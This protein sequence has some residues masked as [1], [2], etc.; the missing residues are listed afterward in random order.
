[1]LKADNLSDLWNLQNI[2]NYSSAKTIAHTCLFS[3]LHLSSKEES[4]DTFFVYFAW[5]VTI[6]TGE[7]LFPKQMLVLKLLCMSEYF[8]IQRQGKHVINP[9]V[10]GGSSSN[11]ILMSCQ[12]HRVT[13]G[14]SNSGHKQIHISKL[15]SHI[16]ISTLCQVNLQNQL[17]ITSQ[18]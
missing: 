15:F 12:P 2:S 16:Y 5:L 11:W 3:P 7:S 18:T 4:G 6:S 13:S 17:A 8:Y 14:Q 10:P 1:M 9:M